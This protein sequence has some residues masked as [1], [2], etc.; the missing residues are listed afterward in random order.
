[1]L[2]YSAPRMKLLSVSLINTGLPERQ[3][4]RIQIKSLEDAADN[5]SSLP[6]K[7][8]FIP[9]NYFLM[10]LLVIGTHC[11]QHTPDR[12]LSKFC[13]IVMW[14]LIT[15]WRLGWAVSFT[16]VLYTSHTQA[17]RYSQIE[18]HQGH[19]L[20]LKGC[21]ASCPAHCPLFYFIIWFYSL[22]MVFSTVSQGLCCTHLVLSPHQ[23]G[24]T[25]CLL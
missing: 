20:E 2:C 16:A 15:H 24:G 8:I 6:T 5:S 3:L 25:G 9:A 18:L 12:D 21:L 17:T 11:T 10:I 7:S 22:K 14:S 23:G 19:K 13:I 1:M 4:H